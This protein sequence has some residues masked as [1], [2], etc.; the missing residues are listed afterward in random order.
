[1]LEKMADETTRF[2]TRFAHVSL[3]PSYLQLQAAV[4]S[5]KF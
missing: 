3:N 1:M 4:N 5:C 2:C